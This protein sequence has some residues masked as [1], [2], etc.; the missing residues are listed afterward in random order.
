MGR[1]L[2]CVGKMLNSYLGEVSDVYE[3]ALPPPDREGDDPRALRSRGI[4]LDHMQGGGQRRLIP[5]REVQEPMP[6]RDAGVIGEADALALERKVIAERSEYA[7]RDS[8]RNLNGIHPTP[9]VQDAPTANMLGSQGIHRTRFVPPLPTTRSVDRD[10]ALF[11]SVPN[12]GGGEV[13]ASRAPHGI[14]RP[15]EMQLG[16]PPVIGVESSVGDT[17]GS[18]ASSVSLR[19]SEQR[20]TAFVSHVDPS[21]SGAASRAGASYVK[22]DS[23]SAPAPL[24]HVDGGVLAAPRS[25]AASR[26]ARKEELAAPAR[27][28]DCGGRTP[29][30]RAFAST[31]RAPRSEGVGGPVV[32]GADSGVRAA[33]ARAAAVA[34]LAKREEI[35]RIFGQPDLADRGAAAA[36][37]RSEYRLSSGDSRAQRAPAVG[38]DG[39]T[40][41]LSRAGATTLSSRDSVEAPR[42]QL[43]V[44]GEAAPPRGAAVSVRR[45]EASGPQ[46]VGGAAPGFASAALE[47]LAPRRCS[48]NRGYAAERRAYG[49]EERALRRDA[50]GR[51]TRQRQKPDLD[52]RAPSREATLGPVERVQG[53]EDRPRRRTPHPRE[54]RA[55]LPPEARAELAPL[56]SRTS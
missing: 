51:E 20:P 6:E 42:R 26:V 9:M 5:K 44:S 30:S 40:A 49:G 10:G 45:A 3:E 15:K 37:G 55:E 27:R 25:G 13:L 4:L 52:A 17:Y 16:A 19:R 48:D 11:P 31:S 41:P 50:G 22:E 21:V 46:Q 38:E 1:E 47:D 54:G 23:S 2:V 53:E 12:S 14:W 35:A 33:P 18:A 36:R 7:L 43:G 24:G 29:P 34:G 56:R 39:A 28:V 32:G 8:M